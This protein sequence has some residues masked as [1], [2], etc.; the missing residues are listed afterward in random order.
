M[1]DSKRVK[2]WYVNDSLDKTTVSVDGV[3][4]SITKMPVF[5]G[6]KVFNRTAKLLSPLI[7]LIGDKEKLDFSVLTEIDDDGVTE[8]IKVLC[9]LCQKDGEMVVFDSDI[10]NHKMPYLLAFEF[11]KW[12]FSDFLTSNPKLKE[13]AEKTMGID[14]EKMKNP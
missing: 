4:F 14:L 7:G 12:N 3:S 13:V 2:R 5:D 1:I 6:M 9:E 11:V 10:K 8:H